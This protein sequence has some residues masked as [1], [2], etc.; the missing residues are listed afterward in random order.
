MEEKEMGD[1]VS[2]K[3]AKFDRDGYAIYED[4]LGCGVGGGGECTRGL[5]GQEESGFAAGEFGS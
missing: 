2:E 1:S 5:V 3:R 4:V